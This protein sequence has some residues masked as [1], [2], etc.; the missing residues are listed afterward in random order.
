MNTQIQIDLSGAPAVDAHCHG[1]TEKGLLKADPETLIS[2]LTLMG[3][4][5]GSSNTG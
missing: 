4:C 1:F 5:M 3:M 2:R